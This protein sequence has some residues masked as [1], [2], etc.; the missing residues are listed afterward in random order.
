MQQFINIA[1]QMDLILSVLNW[2]D[3]CVIYKKKM[4]ASIASVFF[5]MLYHM[6]SNSAF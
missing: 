5:H 6:V 2:S 3:L 4:G 1:L